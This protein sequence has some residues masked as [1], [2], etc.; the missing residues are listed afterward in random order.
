MSGELVSVCMPASRPSRYFDEALS[1][2]LAQSHRRIEVI[3][4]DDSGG[5]LRE[6]AEAAGDPRVRYHANPQPLGLAGNHHRAFEMASGGYVAVLHDDDAWRPRY[7]ERAVEVF[8]ADRRVGYVLNGADEVD[9]RGAMIRRRPT[10]M[11]EGV[12]DD[13]LGHMLDEHFLYTVPSLT[14]WRRPALDASDPPWPDYVTADMKAFIDPVVEG[15]RVHFT[16]AGLVRYRVHD[17]QIGARRQFDHRDGLV[18]LWSAYRFPEPDHEQ[19]RRQ[20]LARWLL[21]RAGSHLEA[22][23][24]KPARA[25]VAAALRADP[26]AGALRCAG[27]ITVSLF[28][29]P[30]GVMALWRRVQDRR[31]H[32]TPPVVST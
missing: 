20:L 6:A 17:G 4:T 7:L 21:A 1:S 16:A 12:Q 32:R 30:D 25:D 14:V 9:A 29:R 10:T 26:S 19:L 24:G 5:Q 28:S 2:A 27:L 11:V 3:V 31:N 8:D 22:G 15:W 23:R 18:K 13:P